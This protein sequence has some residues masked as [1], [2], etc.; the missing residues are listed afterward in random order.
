MWRELGLK[1]IWN[2]GAQSETSALEGTYTLFPGHWSFWG[3]SG[4]NCW[5]HSVPS[6]LSWCSGCWAVLASM[7]SFLGLVYPWGSAGSWWSFPGMHMPPGPWHRMDNRWP[8]GNCCP[9]EGETGVIH[10]LVIGPDAEIF[11]L[12]K[13]RHQGGSYR[14]VQGRWIHRPQKK[15]PKS[16]MDLCLAC[17][18]YPGLVMNNLAFPRLNRL[19]LARLFCL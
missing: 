7:T 12:S 1:I 6:C 3:L 5:N 8:C 10:S 2:V 16:K 13:C 19:Y 18:V 9:A 14:S 17:I 15:I 11:I 4:F